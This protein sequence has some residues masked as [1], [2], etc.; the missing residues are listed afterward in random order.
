MKKVLIV[1]LWLLQSEIAAAQARYL[2]LVGIENSDAGTT[3]S[4]GAEGWEQNLQKLVKLGQG[5]MIA[6]LDWGASETK[7]G[8]YDLQQL[9]LPLEVAQ[10]AHLPVLLLLHTITTTVRALPQDIKDKKLNAPEVTSRFKSFLN[11]VVPRFK[12]RVRWIMVGNEVDIYCSL[13]PDEILC[14]D[15]FYDLAYKEI[16][17]LVPDVKVGLTFSASGIQE[18]PKVFEALSARGDVNCLTYYPLRSDFT[19]EEPSVVDRDFARMASI[20]KQ[21]KFIL[22]EIGYPSARSLGSSELKQA[23]FY[24]NVFRALKK[25]REHI[26][27]A[28]FLHQF[29]WSDETCNSLAGQYG[30]QGNNFR[31]YLCSLGLFNRDNHPK[32]AWHIIVRE[33]SRFA[34]R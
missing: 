7:P 2:P 28:S 31:D 23:E 34:P 14:F 8:H 11:H 1:T 32:K 22:S 29:E 12:G 10:K 18:N 6:N 26:L 4:Y 33:M 19:V 21:R 30:I 27:A 3:Y 24:S 25:Y 16:H 20:S 5:L 17:R 15:Q 13:H 9:D